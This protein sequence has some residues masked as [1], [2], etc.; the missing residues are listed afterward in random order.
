[1]IFQMAFSFLLNTNLK[2]KRGIFK[3]FFSGNTVHHT[4]SFNYT[5]Y[6]QIPTQFFS[7]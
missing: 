4:G 1:M 2:G 6:A 3:V 7:L 5:K